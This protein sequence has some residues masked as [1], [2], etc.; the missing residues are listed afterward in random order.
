MLVLLVLGLLILA[1]IFAFFPRIAWYYVLS[2]HWGR[3]N[4]GAPSKIQIIVVSSLPQDFQSLRYD[5]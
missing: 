2:G 3:N 5:A 1:L 4:L